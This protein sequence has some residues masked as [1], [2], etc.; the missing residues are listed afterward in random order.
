MHGTAMLEARNSN[1]GI[2][3]GH[4]TN[5]TEWIIAIAWGTFG[6]PHKSEIART[7]CGQIGRQI[8]GFLALS[9]IAATVDRL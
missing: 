7:L 1:R 5:R 2:L 4:S 6:K 8:R 3:L 9:T